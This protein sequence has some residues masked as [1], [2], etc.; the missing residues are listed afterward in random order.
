MRYLIIIF[1]ICILTA[2]HLTT[3]PKTAKSV[4]MYSRE[5]D[6]VG[7]ATLTE[8]PEGVEIELKLE[9]LTPGWHGLHIH[10]IGECE[11]PD[12][13]S[14]G[15]HFNPENKEHGL[16]HPKGPHVGDLP[17]I[18]ADHNGK[19]EETVVVREATLLEGKNSLTEKSGTALIVTSQ[20]DDGIRQISGD[21]GERIICGEIKGED[22]KKDEEEPSDPTEEGEDEEEA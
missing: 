14:A 5:G 10:E 6:M 22:E 3:E 2:C 15:N 18:E 7:T 17:N 13:K 9:G 11:A 20:R 8:S 4:E 1:S 16:L 12:F 21:S 19:V